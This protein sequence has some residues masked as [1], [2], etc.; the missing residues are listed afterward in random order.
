MKV[1]TCQF[2][3]F[4]T[5]EFQNEKTRGEVHTLVTEGNVAELERR[6][7]SRIEFGTA[8]L[9]GRMAAGISMMNDVVVIQTSQ[10]SS[11]LNTQVC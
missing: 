3:D 7:M 5:F 8:G 11:K 10:V 2:S 4:S 1:F 9:R 6:F